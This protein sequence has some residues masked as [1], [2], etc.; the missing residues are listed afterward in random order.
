ME[1]DA[2]LETRL[3]DACVE[4]DDR[5]WRQLHRYYAPIASSF[6]RKLG[7][8]EQDAEDVLQEVFFEMWRSLHQFRREARLSTWLYKICIAQRDRFRRRA[9]ALRLLR[10]LLLRAVTAT[11][12][13]NASETIA[14]QTLVRA[15]DQLP[16]P[17]RIAFILF[18]ME[19]LKGKEIAEIMGWPES[20]VWPRVHNAR[21]LIKD[22][23]KDS[24]DEP[25][26]KPHDGDE[27]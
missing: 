15:L 18:N 10:K 14:L 13:S 20:S 11:T 22:A 8:S 9:W 12:P 26:T 6:L 3:L 25:S 23:L 2:S 27:T 16:E 17:E 5:A 1:I 7:L 24:P 21:K 4:G 19:G